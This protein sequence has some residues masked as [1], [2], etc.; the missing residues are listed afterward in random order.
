VPSIRC[1]VDIDGAAYGT[2]QRYSV[3]AD[4][5]IGTLHLLSFLQTRS[6]NILSTTS[7]MENGGSLMT[8]ISDKRIMRQ[9]N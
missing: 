9:H 7:G 3:A 4:N 1:Q 5:G 6:V 2:V 8:R